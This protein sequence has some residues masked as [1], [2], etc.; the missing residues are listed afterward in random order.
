M[1]KI[2]INL[3]KNHR[4]KARSTMKVLVAYICSHGTRYLSTGCLFYRICSNKALTR[5][6][7]LKS[8]C[9]MTRR[10]RLYEKG[11]KFRWR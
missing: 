1:M 8:G 3:W 2:V 11:K 9:E 5:K 10:T 7:T 4:K 6:I